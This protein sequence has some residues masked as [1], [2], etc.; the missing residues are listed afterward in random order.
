[1]KAFFIRV[2]EVDEM[3]AVSVQTPPLTLSG[4]LL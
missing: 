2:V 4:M 3:S 1:M